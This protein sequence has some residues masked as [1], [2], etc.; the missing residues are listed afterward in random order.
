MTIHFVNLISWSFF[1]DKDLNDS[2]VFAD[3][4][5]F[6]I[7]ARLFGIKLKQNSGVANVAQ[8]CNKISTGYLLSKDNSIPNSFVL[9]FWKDLNE[10]TLNHELL[11]F[12]SKYDNIVIAI[13]SPK[14]DKLAMLINKTQLNKK[15][16]C[17]GA[18]V[19]INKT[20]KFL[21]N[22]NLT[23]LGFLLSNPLR[24]LNKIYYTIHSIIAILFDHNTKLNFIC[25]AKKINS[26][27]LLK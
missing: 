19:N 27:N 23:W 1:V 17:L 2:I 16:Y 14:Q 6:C 11:N 9:P 7:I 15:I 4:I 24:T 18:A 3:S 22:F 12:I 26:E 13:S 20:I 25:L 10:I 8:I 5:T 21:E